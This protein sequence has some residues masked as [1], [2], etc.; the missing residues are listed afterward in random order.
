[1][2]GCS[3]GTGRRAFSYV[4]ISTAPQAQGAGI[5]RQIERAVLYASEHGFELDN[6]LR[7]I[8][9]SAF[10]G[11]HRTGALGGFLAAVQAGA[12]PRGSV[13]LIEALDRLSREEM[14]DAL[15]LVVELLAS[16]IDIIT[17]EDGVTY[18][19]LTLKMEMHVVHVLTSKMQQANQF[20]TR[21]SERVTHGKKLARERKIAAGRPITRMCPAFYRVVDDHYEVIPQRAAIIRR[22]FDELE[23]GIGKEE[24][25]RQLNTERVPPFDRAGQGL[26]STR[27][28]KGWHVSYLT[29]LVRNRA[30]VGD[31]V[32][33]AKNHGNGGKP[34]SVGEA[35]LNHYGPG[36][37]SRQQFDRVNAS[38][39]PAGRRGMHY[40]NVLTGLVRCVCGATM[41]IKHKG[42]RRPDAAKRRKDIRSNSYLICDSAFRGL[43]CQDRAMMAYRPLEQ[44]ILRLATD[45][46]P[47]SEWLGAQGS[48]ARGRRELAAK[49]EDNDRRVAE[50]RAQ[51]NYA[52][53]H[54]GANPHQSIMDAIQ[55][56]T[57]EIDKLTRDRAKLEAR[58]QQ[59]PHSLPDQEL[60]TLV[61]LAEQAE[62]EQDVRERY[63]MRAR[64]HAI[65]TRCIDIIIVSAK[66]NY[67]R[68][69]LGGGFYYAVS[70]QTGYFE[71][72]V[73]GRVAVR[74]DDR[75]RLEGMTTPPAI[76]AE[77]EAIR[78]AAGAKA[79][80]CQD[81]RATV[82][83]FYELGPGQHPQPFTIDF[84]RLFY[85]D[86]PTGNG[87]P[88]KPYG[89]DAEP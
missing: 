45:L 78:S 71:M 27:S 47:R 10:S 86:H 15:S 26:A 38:R 72:V 21:L 73:D 31:F 22:I 23:A 83:A 51:I 12:I 18:S 7:D 60:A 67:W 89:R 57:T 17:L 58:A 14:L 61:K 33:T 68:A 8:G 28:G 2:L 3:T 70:E 20:S 9:R 25:V 4:R 48:A 79:S 77:H 85:P 43:G 55:E 29:K 40:H 37:V 36:I 11:A 46:I 24:I 84:R 82:S 13:L 54:L 64:M 5:E 16:E 32:P 52:V 19:R 88:K 6:S 30:V 59:K 1:M 39:K 35:I 41:I 81:A 65:F 50:L 66:R 56:M 53:R 44:V 62:A 42:E 69:W 74:F 63:R 34:Q 49:I 87:Q 80:Y 76:L 75:L